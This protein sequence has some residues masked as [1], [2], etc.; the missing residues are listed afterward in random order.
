VTFSLSDNDL[1]LQ[2]VAAAIGLGDQPGTDG[3]DW[4]FGSNENVVLFGGFGNDTISARNGDDAVFGEAGDDSL[5]GGAGSD[6]LSG[7]VGDDQID[8]NAGDDWVNGGQGDDTL[9]GGTGSDI[10]TGG[11]G[12]DVFILQPGNGSD[13]ITDFEIGSDLI[14]L[15]GDV[16]L[17]D[18][19][20]TGSDI[21][22]NDE[23]LATLIG[24]DTT[25][26]TEDDYVMV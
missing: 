17:D 11:D 12:N 23:I 24:L 13:R 26:L 8:G 5:D 15:A 10:V 6:A 1:S 9:D 3:D 2:K 18:L 21:A 16:A 25:A 19:T 22:L 4:I 14:A 7:G 20:F